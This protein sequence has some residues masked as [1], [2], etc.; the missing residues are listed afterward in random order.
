MCSKCSDFKAS[1]REMAIHSAEQ[2]RSRVPAECRNAATT[3]GRSVGA[4]VGELQF[5]AHVFAAQQGD[6]CLQLVAALTGDFDGVALDAGMR[7]LFGILYQAHDLFSLLHR[8]TL[9]K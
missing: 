7:L 1:T 8:N 5:Q 6:N 2:P 3:A 9:L 4:I